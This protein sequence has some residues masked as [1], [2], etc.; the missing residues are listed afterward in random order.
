MT[1]VGGEKDKVMG[2]SPMAI[3]NSYLFSAGGGEKFTVMMT[4]EKEKRG[5]S[6]T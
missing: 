1:A 2:A 3:S 5:D 4:G 6:E